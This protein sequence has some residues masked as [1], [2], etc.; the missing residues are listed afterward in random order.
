[1]LI[2][3]RRK[4]KKEIYGKFEIVSKI[5]VRIIIFKNLLNV[6]TFEYQNVFLSI[7]RNIYNETTTM[8]KTITI[9]LRDRKIDLNENKWGRRDPHCHL[10]KA[11]ERTHPPIKEYK[12]RGFQKYWGK[13]FI[14]SCRIF[15]T[16]TIQPSPT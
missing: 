5:E 8:K 6:Y 1:M 15:S 13:K 14:T 9:T 7:V 3:N 10:R 11:S 2:K 4:K 16:P 12:Q